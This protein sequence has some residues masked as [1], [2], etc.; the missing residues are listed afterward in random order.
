MAGITR[1]AGIV[2]REPC[3]GQILRCMSSIGDRKTGSKRYAEDRLFGL[4]IHR[5][6]RQ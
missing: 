2:G 1:T 5:V 4:S 3:H 6:R